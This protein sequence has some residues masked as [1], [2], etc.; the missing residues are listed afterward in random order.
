[1]PLHL[2]WKMNQVARESHGHSHLLHHHH[3]LHQDMEKAFKD[4]KLI[5][6]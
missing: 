3:I 4:S 5:E 6:Q 2:D 1:M